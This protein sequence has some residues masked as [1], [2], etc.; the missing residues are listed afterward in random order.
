MFLS[1]A[2]LAMAGFAFRDYLFGSSLYD[3][4]LEYRLVLL[5]DG[6]HAFLDRPWLGGGYQASRTIS[7]SP[8][9]QH[10]VNA[11]TLVTTNTHIQWLEM[12]VSYGTPRWNIVHCLLGDHRFA[13]YSHLSSVFGAI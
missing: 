13:G 4:S 5:Q 3:Q 2:L 9:L 7:W 11:Q 8:A 12:Y 6:V 1:G 10:F